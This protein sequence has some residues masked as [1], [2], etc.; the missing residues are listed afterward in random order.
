MYGN[1]GSQDFYALRSPSGHVTVNGVAAGANA[2]EGVG[3]SVKVG[4]VVYDQQGVSNILNVNSS[5]QDYQR[6]APTSSA[7]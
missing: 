4:T 1:V 3:G 2:P 7:S 5:C 6:P